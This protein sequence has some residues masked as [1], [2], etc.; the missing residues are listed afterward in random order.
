[1]TES[2][3]GL[4]YD[5]RKTVLLKRLAE[6]A[7]GRIQLLTGP[8]QVGKTTLLLELAKEFGEAAHF[9]AM[10]EPQAGLPGFW[11]RTWND[12]EQRA[13]G[14]PAVLFV[15]EIQKVSDWPARIKGNYDRIKR[16]KTP[17]H[18][19]ASGSSALGL[20]AGSRESLAGRFERLTLVRFFPSTYPRSGKPWRNASSRASIP[21]RGDK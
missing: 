13:S 4:H 17:L 20:R 1:M 15:D 16:R 5:G 9:V 14:G 6:P 10:D 11:E 3:F 7:P 19:V 8:R 2:V 21:G 18:I 12:A